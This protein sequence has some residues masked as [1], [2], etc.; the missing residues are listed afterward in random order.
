MS[1]VNKENLNV[2][3]WVQ[4]FVLSFVTHCTMW[5][6]CVAQMMN[7]NL[8]FFKIL[9]FGC[10]IAWKLFHIFESKLFKQEHKIDH[11]SLSNRNYV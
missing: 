1:E 9:C 2:N 6:G 10:K 3:Y 11:V 7:D 5:Y 4:I 8:L